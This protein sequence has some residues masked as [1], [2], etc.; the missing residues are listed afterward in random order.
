VIRGDMEVNETKLA[1][2]VKASP[3]IALRSIPDSF[4]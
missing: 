1:N 3:S 4:S 2:A